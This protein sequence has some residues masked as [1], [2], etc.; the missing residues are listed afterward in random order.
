[1]TG[2]APTVAYYECVQ[3]APPSAPWIVL[4]HGVSQDRRVFSAQVQ[5]FRRTFRLMLIDLPGHG[6]STGCP[7][8][9]G[10]DEFA[11]SIRASIRSAGLAQPHF[12]GTHIGAGA[13]L[14]LAAREPHLFGSLLLE[15]PVFPGRRLQ[16]GAETVD[17]VAARAREQGI[18]AARQLWWNDSG[19]FAVMR[20][21]PK[22]CRAEEQRAVIG[23]FQGEPWLDRRLTAAIT[24]IDDALRRCSVRTLIMNG[25]YDMDDFLRAA[26]QL[27]ELLPNCR[28]TTVAEAGG[29]PFWE[30]PDRVNAEALAFFA[31]G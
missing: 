5:A 23:D 30:F 2:A 8:P 28:R 25:E 16:A 10:L 6:R 27:A 29:F 19:W 11:A 4:V 18:E 13:G 7:G 31:A 21:R 9:F 12:W 24:P 26:E 20:A 14:L 15:A 1:M 3:D 22:D 17:R